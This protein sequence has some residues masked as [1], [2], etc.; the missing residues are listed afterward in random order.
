MNYY[1]E[2][3]EIVLLIYCFFKIKILNKQIANQ[4]IK[5]PVPIESNSNP[6][7]ERYYREVQNRKFSK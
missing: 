5:V 2:G 3:I 7:L 6:L 4:Q 1:L